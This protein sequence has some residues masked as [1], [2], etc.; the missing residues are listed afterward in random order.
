MILFKDGQE[1]PGSRVIGFMKAEPFLN[2][3]NRHFP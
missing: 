2:H 3:L 1:V